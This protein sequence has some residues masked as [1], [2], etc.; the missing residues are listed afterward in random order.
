MELRPGGGSESGLS[1]SGGHAC[2]LRA[3]S[4]ERRPEASKPKLVQ[5]QSAD[6]AAARIRAHGFQSVTLVD[7]LS[8]G[9]SAGERDLEASTERAV[10]LAKEV[11]KLRGLASIAPAMLEGEGLS[12]FEAMKSMAWME[13]GRRLEQAGKGEEQ[14]VSGPEAIADYLRKKLRDEKREHFVVVLLDS[15]NAILRYVTVHIGTLTSSIVGPREVFR[16]AIRE[17]ASRIILAHN[18]P[19]GDPQPS[20]E[21]REITRK[22]AEIGHM[23]DIPV[24]DHVI[25]GE[26]EHRSLREEGLIS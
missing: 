5:I 4:Q 15:K 26:R 21:D 6:S 13:I 8:V 19:S 9:L 10:A 25:V 7:L 2:R 12:A 17:G 14:E 11:G 18:H 3:R 22:M 16:E 1:A 20:R 23:L 24:L